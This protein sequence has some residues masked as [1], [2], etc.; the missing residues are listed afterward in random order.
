MINKSKSEQL[1][2]IAPNE[3]K[4]DIVDQLMGLSQLS[5]FSLSE[6]NG[7]SREHSQFDIREQVEGYRKFHRFEIFLDSDETATVLTA[8]KPVCASAAVRYWILPVLTAGS[9]DTL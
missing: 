3:I 1:I 7:Y 5:G 4:D 6:I 8:L 2:L 9:F